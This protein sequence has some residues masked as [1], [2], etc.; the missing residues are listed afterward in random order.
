[1]AEKRKDFTPKE[2]ERQKLFQENAI[3]DWYVYLIDFFRLRIGKVK[4]MLLQFASISRNLSLGF[5]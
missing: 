5:L 1:M 2:K 3:L 4:N